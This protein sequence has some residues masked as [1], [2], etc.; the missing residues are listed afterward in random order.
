[1][2]RNSEGFMQREIKPCRIRSTG[3]FL[4]DRVDSRYIENKFGLPEGWSEKH[5]GV[6]F[7][8]QVKP[9]QGVADLGAK[10]AQNALDLASLSL[11][12]IDVLITAGASTDQIIPSQAAM[13]LAKMKAGR[14][15]RCET[16][17]VNTTCLSF[18]TAFGMASDMLQSPETK[19]VLIVAS[20]VS[21]RGIGPENWE[22]LTLFGDGAAAVVLEKSPDQKSGVVF[23]QQRTYTEGIK[24]AEIPGGCIMKWIEDFP[25][26]PAIH[27]FQ[28][29]GRELLR[30]TLRFL[31]EFMDD[32][33]ASADTSWPE[34]S[35][36]VPHQASKTGLG[37]IPKLADIDPHRVVN[38]LQNTG[39]CIAASI[40]MAVHHL[41]S[42][43][44]MKSGETMLLVGTSA[45]YSIGALLYQHG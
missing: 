9:G 1:M 41:F 42:Q 5:S 6:A 21:S 27:H 14:D 35:W 15:A 40:P 16:L 32:F 23:R 4:P 8:H 34:I 45:G 28:M 39:N 22:T 33:F 31:P 29:D 10:A 2:E 20:E 37:M 3:L 43:N 18:V 13:T 25:F 19:K 44:Q 24:S 7:R 30:L 38:I 26:D 36:T 17:H 11:H 12:D